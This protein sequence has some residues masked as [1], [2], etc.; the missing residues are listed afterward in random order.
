MEPI[1]SSG[2]QQERWTP[3]SKRLAMGVDGLAQRDSFVFSAAAGRGSPVACS[4]D[5]DINV[6]TNVHLQ[7]IQLTADVAGAK[8]VQAAPDTLRSAK[9]I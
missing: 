3:G 1:T 4:Y 8:H 7:T 9:F 2:W 6:T 5:R